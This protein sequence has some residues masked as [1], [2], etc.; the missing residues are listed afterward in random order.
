MNIF[1]E[2]RIY[3]FYR[4]G[5]DLIGGTLVENISRIGNQVEYLLKNTA[6][7]DKRDLT[8]VATLHINSPFHKQTINYLN[9]LMDE[10][11]KNINPRLK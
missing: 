5:N 6:C 7:L 9:D 3:Y 4:V 11:F 1:E 2:Y 10:E 8:I